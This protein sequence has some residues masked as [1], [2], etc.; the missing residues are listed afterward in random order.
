MLEIE[1]P[2]LSAFAKRNMF[3]SLAQ[4]RSCPTYFRCPVAPPA[5]AGSPPA[6][7]NLEE[8]AEPVSMCVCVCVLLWAVV[9]HVGAFGL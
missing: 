4:V 7:W 2:G 5:L 3:L 6:A 9:V 1:K 8:E